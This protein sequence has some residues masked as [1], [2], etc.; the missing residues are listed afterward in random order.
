MDVCGQTMMNIYYKH[1]D[2]LNG[3]CHDTNTECA[4]G[5]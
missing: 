3:G 5:P 4:I 2:E 1:I